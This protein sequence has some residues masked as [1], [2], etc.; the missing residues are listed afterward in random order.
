MKAAVIREHGGPDV[1]RI[2]DMPAP[3]PGRRDA[4]GH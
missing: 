2:E 1:M 3:E 4:A